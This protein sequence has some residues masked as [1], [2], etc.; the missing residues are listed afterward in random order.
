MAYETPSRYPQ[1]MP[2]ILSTTEIVPTIRRAIASIDATLDEIVSRVRD[3]GASSSSSSSEGSREPPTFENV[4]RPY[5]DAHNAL[6]E[7]L[8]V[9]F[10]LQY[11]A[12]DPG[13]QDAVG[14]AIRAWT[15]ASAAWLAREDYY[16]RLAAVSESYSSSSSAALDRESRQLLTELL[17][18]YRSAGHGATPPLG[19]AGRR[20]ILDRD[21]AIADRCLAFQ[22]NVSREAGGLRFTRAQLA[23]V[24]GERVAAWA[25]ATATAPCADGGGDEEEDTVFVPFANG[26]ANVV[27]THARDPAT[28]RRMH[29]GDQRK[30]PQNDALLRGIVRLRRRQAAALGHASH[31]A[32]R[33]PGRLMKT[34]AGIAGFLD[35]LA[36]G[37]VELGR[38][39]IRA[40][41]ERRARDLG[42]DEN[43]AADEGIGGSGGGSRRPR[44]PAWD[45]VYY[46]RMVKNELRIDHQKISEYFPLERTAQAMLG[47][48]KS[49]LGLRFER[50]P[51]SELGPRQIWHP[52]VQAFAVWEEDGETFVGFLFLDLLFREHKYRGNQNVTHETGYLKPDG[53]RKYP[54]TILMCSFPT[55]T[56]EK[57]ALLKHTEVVTMFHELG[58]GIHNLCS[59]TRYARFHGT[60][61]PPDFGE[62]PS[63]MLENFCWMSDVLKRISCHYTSGSEEY[64]QNWRDDHPGCPDPPDEIPDE[65][66]DN[67]IKH[68][69]LHRAGYH[70]KQLSIS[71][72]DLEIHSVSTPAEAEALNLRER[73]YALREECESLDFGNRVR[74]ADENGVGGNYYGAFTHL[75]AGYDVGYYSYLVCTAFAQDV[76]RTAF[77][78]S[79]GKGDGRQEGN[80]AFDRAVWERYRREILEPGGGHDDMIMLLQNFLGRRPKAEAL[81]ETLREAR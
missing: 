9:V 39:E 5:A 31:A 22:R 54:S 15:Q 30:L 80:P 75:T 2:Y 77:S 64:L 58:H 55:S 44:L 17:R 19:R 49:L 67:L 59:R 71:L 40:L 12:A 78:P 34:V 42:Y 52:D 23:G 38:A 62:M 28:R 43:A 65:L 69:Y 47:I 27:L 76:F 24:P 7:T 20:E 79:G 14:D 18:D 6:S 81:L 66:I 21:V 26:G 72:F 29:E 73:F 46:S 25:A 33:A 35:A 61:L 70:L 3:A 10:M 57:P 4:V 13:T 45:L 53:S 50:I 60:L 1:R 8:G 48:F 63:V 11:A 16:A 32:L 68:R 51:Q 74:N 41:G 56:P 37:L 36:P